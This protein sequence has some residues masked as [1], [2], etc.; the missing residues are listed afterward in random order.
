MAILPQIHI[1][2]FSHLNH[3]NTPM[4]T[5]KQK[6][7]LDA[8]AEGK[9]LSQAQREARYSEAYIHSGKFQKTKT[10]KEMVDKYLD[11]KFLLEALRE[12]IISKP[13]NRKEELRLAFQLKGKLI[14]KSEIDLREP[15]PIVPILGGITRNNNLPV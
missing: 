4:T 5:P 11:D 8:I 7:V 15:T 14:Q 10:Y 3:S 2:D 6:K 13:N 1:L 9:N 12:D